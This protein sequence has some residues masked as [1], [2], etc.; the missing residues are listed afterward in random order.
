MSVSNRRQFVEQ[1]EI[2]TAELNELLHQAIIEY[3]LKVKIKSITKSGIPNL[4]IS[5]SK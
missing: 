5:L 4:A 2:K 1:I 3:D